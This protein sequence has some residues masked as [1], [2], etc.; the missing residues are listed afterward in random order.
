MSR[1]NRRAKLASM[2]IRSLGHASFRIKGKRAIVVTDPYNHPDMGFKMPRVSADMVTVSHGHRD[3]NYVEGV[4]KTSRREPFVI[5]GP[6]EYEIMGAAVFG[7]PSYHD[8]SQGEERGKNT[9]YVINMD[10]IRLAHLG[11]LGH[12]LSEKQLEKINGVDILFVPVGGIVTI[13]PKEAAEL[14][15]QIEPGIVIPMHYQTPDLKLKIAPSLAP[16]ED[17][18]KEMGVEGKPVDK[19]VVSRD[20]LPEERTVVVLKRKS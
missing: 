11:D 8:S 6:G 14:V 16:V 1:G 20:K 4:T 3:H 13:G 10:G 12:L 19:L 9:I 7:I 17:F 15:S 18:L 5:S 2:E